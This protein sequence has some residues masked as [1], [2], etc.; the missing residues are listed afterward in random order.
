MTCFRFEPRDSS[1][2]CVDAV[3]RHH[4]AD[5]GVTGREHPVAGSAL[6]VLQLPVNVG[7]VALLCHVIGKH[8][9]TIVTFDFLDLLVDNF[10]VFLKILLDGEFHG[11]DVTFKSSFV[12][13]RKV[14]LYTRVLPSRIVKKLKKLTKIEDFSFLSMHLEGL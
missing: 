13:Q 4:V 14:T 7:H 5:H 12:L 6:V 10:D 2:S 1:N 11:T 3:N 8:F 9:V